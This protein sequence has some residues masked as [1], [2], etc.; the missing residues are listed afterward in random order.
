[1]HLIVG[2]TGSVGG[3]V[4]EHLLAGSERVRALV[5]KDSAARTEGS[6]TD[7]EHLR[8]LGAEIVFGDLADPATLP[9]ALDGVRH[10]I[11]TANTAKRAPDFETVDWHGT[12]DLIDAAAKAGVEHFVYLSAVGAEPGSPL[13]LFHAKG[14]IEEHLKAS[15]LDHTIVRPV[16]FMEDWIGYLLGAQLEHAG[17]I[18]L[19]NGGEKVLSFV[20]A[21]DVALVLASLVRRP[22]VKSRVVTLGAEASTHRA[23]VPLVE[24]ATGRSVA[25]SSV[26]AG[27]EIP[28]LPPVMVNLWAAMANGPD[29]DVVS[30]EVADEL[31]VKLQSIESFVA[32]TFGPV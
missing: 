23:I 18:R 12:R 30:T 24:E 20:S 1:M 21:E 31:G 6:H 15:G 2:A 3:K 14:R 32:R 13:P 22:H 19:L 10:V 16:L 17:E 4:A 29:M 7:P 9:P 11:S 8:D 27:E 28:G 5:R 25:V 26:A